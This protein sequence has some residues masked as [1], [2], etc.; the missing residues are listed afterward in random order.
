MRN[1][2]GQDIGMWTIFPVLK[3]KNVILR[4]QKKG[5]SYKDKDGRERERE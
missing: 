4:V 2:Q 3:N 5:E 1:D